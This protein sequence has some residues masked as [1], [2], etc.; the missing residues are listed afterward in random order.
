M[1]NFC[2][3]NLTMRVAVLLAVL[4][5]ATG[6]SKAQVPLPAGRSSALDASVGYT[7]VDMNVPSSAHVGLNGVDTAL[8]A[9]LLPRIGVRADFCY[10]RSGELYGRKRYN[11]VMT[12]L[13]GPIAYPLRTRH[14]SIYVD[15]LVGGARVSGVNE[16]ENGGFYT[17]FVNKLAWSFGAGGSYQLSSTLA[18]GFGLDYFHS[19][20]FDT[21]GQTRGVWN[22]RATVSL[23]YSFGR[24]RR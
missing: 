1:L 20:F 15:A 14:V 10:A 18:V 11:D 8:T 19:S 12:Y 13:G 22:P 6:A 21:S 7:Y 2:A 9:S 23:I 16:A 3:P 4:L 5:L 24:H 17:G